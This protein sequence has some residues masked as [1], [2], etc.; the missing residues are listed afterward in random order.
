MK[1]RFVEQ[2]EKEVNYTITENG[3]V[4]FK[5][6]MN[7]CLD[8]F[9]SLGAMRFSSED[10]IINTFSKAYYEDRPLALKMAFYMRDIR[11]GQGQRRVFRVI[12]KWL[13]ENYP[14]DVINNLNNILEYGRGD[15]F[16]CLFGTQVEHEMINRIRSIIMLDS[17]AVD[18]KESCT[19]LAKWLPSENTSSS[20][21]RNL[22]RKLIKAL[23]IS[24]RQYRTILSKIR[25]YIDVTEVKMSA[26]KW[27]DINYNTVPAKAAMNY[28]NAFMRHDMDN[29]VDYLQH[30]SVGRA[31][32]NAKS[33][34]PV[35]IIHKVLSSRG[36]K[37]DRVVLNAMWEA[38]PNYFTDEEETGICMVD[39]SASMYGLP[40]EVAL[41]LGIYCADKCRG[42]FKNH[43]I[44]FN[45]KPDFVK[46]RGNNIYEKVHNI[47]CINSGNTNIEAA[48]DLILSAAIKGN[49]KQ[50]DM[51][52]KLYII[53]D[54]QFDQARGAGYISSWCKTPEQHFMASMKKKFE[55]AGY[56]MPALIYWNVRASKCGMFQDTFDGEDCAMVSGYS[57]SLFKSIID[58]TT[59]EEVID[60]NGDVTVKEKIDPMTVMLNT[61][62][63]ERYN[64]VNT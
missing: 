50:E 24:P 38:L 37:K 16:M 25:K 30:L 44:T 64:L 49:C 61:L 27:E 62:N 35:D 7:A 48:F 31:K 21:T 41:S 18:K 13:A 60:S 9:G 39:T 57:A 19:L 22:A 47:G 55:N 1:N 32:I 46:T 43:F 4:A 26:N 36:D 52:S 5:S 51:P 12:L 45:Y 40:Y 20:E 15:D 58:G 56:K 28:S 2:M 63:S 54:M 8:A 34:F 14:N 53:S 29:Y 3:A 59:Y 6:T 11:G 17:I 10:E 42:P 33:L 23:D